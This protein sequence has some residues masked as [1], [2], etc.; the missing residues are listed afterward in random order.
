MIGSE[1]QNNHINNFFKKIPK[2]FKT[3][4]KFQSKEQSTKFQMNNK[5]KFCYRNNLPYYGKQTDETCSDNY[6]EETDHRIEERII[7]PKK[8]KKNS[9]HPIKACETEHNHMW[10]KDFKII[11]NDDCSTFKK[12]II[13]ALFTKQLKAILDKKRIYFRLSCLIYFLLCVILEYTDQCL[14]ER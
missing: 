13:K 2:D 9:H 10:N 7:E 8:C 14:Q 5:T 4:V 6:I 3:I 12:K 11:G 1:P